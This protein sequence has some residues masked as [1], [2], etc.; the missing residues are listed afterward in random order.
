MHENM[1]I[2]GIAL[3]ILGYGFFS[4]YLSR[5]NISGPM[6]FTVVGILLS[7]L[8]FGTKS[9]NFNEEMVQTIAEITLILVL[10]SDA[11]ALN[12]KKLKKEW[13]LPARLLFIGLPITIAFS[14]Y[15]AKIF[16]PDESI[17][18]LLL[19]ALILAPTDAALG[20]AVVSDVKVPENIRSSINVESG[21]N[22]GIVFPVLITVVAIA[23]SGTVGEGQG[24]GWL[25]DVLKQVLFG[26]VIGAFVGFAG[27]RL[28]SWVIK[29]NWMEEQYENLV[30]IAIAI[31][32]YYLAEHFGGNGFIAAFFSGLFIGNLSKELRDNIENF[33]ESEGEFLIMV[34]FLVFGITFVP[35]FIPYLDFNVLFYSI[36]S[37]TILRML[38]V[39]LSL[40]GKEKFPTMIFVGW[41][42]PRG[43]ASILYMLIVIHELGSIKGHEKIFAVMTLTIFLSIFLHG[44][45][46]KPF[47]N[48]YGKFNKTLA[49]KEK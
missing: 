24:E 41:F 9:V 7:T 49:K 4:K 10:F 11:A 25:G 12:L 47:A 39:A 19:L 1:T 31:F 29:K 28:A 30:P 23:L 17:I 37:L 32:S 27:A 40:I 48:L 18:Y 43:I 35:A 46:A 2:L 13:K 16:F 14:F 38:P 26:A 3:V 42:G 44:L 22:D 15:V 36:L 21:L 34:C 8:F 20:K 33:A 6:V 5:N 45:S